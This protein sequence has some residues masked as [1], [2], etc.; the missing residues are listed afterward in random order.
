MSTVEIITRAE[1]YRRWTQADRDRILA[2]FDLPGAVI[3]RVAEKYEIAPSLIHKWRKERRE[4][5]AAKQ[6]PAFVQYGAIEALQ[7]ETQDHSREERT[8]ERHEAIENCDPD[9][10]AFMEIAFPTGERLII[11]GEMSERTIASAIGC[12]RGR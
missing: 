1:R 12:L 4:E 11:H 2:E 5:L 10:R 8:P 6:M 7:L 3:L 9:R